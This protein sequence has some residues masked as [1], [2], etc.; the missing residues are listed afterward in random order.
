VLW[1][2]F[3]AS[4]VLASDASGVPFTVLVK[5]PPI[6][7][8]VF[9]AVF[10]CRTI[11]PTAG[12]VYALHPI[13]VLI[14]GYHGQFDSLMLA[15]AF[16]AWYLFDAWQGW[17]RVISSG[18]ALGLGI[19]FKPVPLVLVPVL[20]FRLPTWPQR[21]AFGALSVAPAGLGTLPYLLRW[22]EDVAVNFLGYSSW[23]G[24]WGYP[25]VWMLVEYIR[26][27][28]IPWWLPDPDFVSEPLQ[29]MFAV[30]RWLLLAALATAWIVSYRRGLSTLR[31][32]I[33]TFSIF[34]FATVGFGLQYL[35]WI[36][37]FAIVAR[38]RMLWPYTLAGTALLL[39]AYLVGQAY[40]APQGMLDFAELDTREFLVK[41]V[42]LPTWL[43]CGVWALASLTRRPRLAA[44]NL[45]A[46]QPVVATPARATDST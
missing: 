31:S 35:L 44:P 6:A 11:G 14:T 4:A 10:L 5:L 22:P 38:D 12:L 27:H 7:A 20:L 1:I 2:Y 16:V 13:A 3:A 41:L 28:T 37:P 19:W 36:V 40:L 32:I 15:S 18:L 24:Q 21:L 46:P 9:L 30:G 43:I 25:V 8:D 26:D 45:R 29:V 42:T 33:A 39:T 34:Y 23:F 17:R